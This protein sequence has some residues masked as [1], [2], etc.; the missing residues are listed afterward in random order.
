MNPTKTNP[1]AF[2]TG[3]AFIMNIDKLTEGHFAF[4]IAALNEWLHDMQID[5]K[6]IITHFA[7]FSDEVIAWWL[8][9]GFE[10]VIVDADND[11]ASGAV[12]AMVKDAHRVFVASSPSDLIEY[13]RH[14]DAPVFVACPRSPG[15]P[16]SEEVKQ[17]ATAIWWMERFLYPLPPPINIAA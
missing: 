7:R 4:D 5:Q 10:V 9:H 3:D 13:H 8:G 14:I 15:Q 6:V 16:I 11:N 12:L 2:T 1:E 17:R